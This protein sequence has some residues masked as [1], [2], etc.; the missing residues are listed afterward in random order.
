MV[1]S[2][3]SDSGWPWLPQSGLHVAELINFDRGWP[4]HHRTSIAQLSREQLV[5]RFSRAL[6]LRA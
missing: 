3:R 1:V 2:C 6:K 5:Q 4:I